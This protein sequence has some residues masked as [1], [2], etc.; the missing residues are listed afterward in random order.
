MFFS[1]AVTDVWSSKAM[2]YVFWFC[3]PW[4]LRPR[5][6]PMR[7]FKSERDMRSSRTFTPAGIVVGT[8]GTCGSVS[9]MCA[10]ESL[11]SSSVVRI[12]CRRPMRCGGVPTVAIEILGASES[13]LCEGVSADIVVISSLSVHTSRDGVSAAVVGNS[14]VSVPILCEGDPADVKYAAWSVGNP[15]DEAPGRKIGVLGDASNASNGTYELSP[16]MRS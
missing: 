7:P 10:K 5:M 11:R 16:R 4:T 15:V 2:S 3:L 12:A 8:G 6:V 13:C 9:P 1:Q 14:C